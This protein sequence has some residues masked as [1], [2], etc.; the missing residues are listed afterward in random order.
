MI[1]VSFVFVSVHERSI[2]LEEIAV[3]T[4]LPGGFGVGPEL[5]LKFQTDDHAV[6]PVL[7]VALTRQ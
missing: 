2:W 3:A 5:V 1:F 7:V 6:V 4:R